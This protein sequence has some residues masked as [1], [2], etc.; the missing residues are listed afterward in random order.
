M[1][2]SVKMVIDDPSKFGLLATEVKKAM[3]QAAIA[4]VNIQA[5]LGRKAAVK[6]IEKSFTTRNTFTTRQ[7]QFTPMPESKYVKIS[8]IQST[9]GATDKAPYMARQEE[10]G[11]HTPSRGATLAIPTDYA[12]GGSSRSLVKRQM[13]VGNITGKM[14]VH[15]EA[16]LRKKAFKGKGKKVPKHKKITAHGSRK[17]WTVARAYIAFKHGLFLPYEGNS[18][19]RNLFRVTSFSKNGKKVKFKMV[20]VYSFEYRSTRTEE[21]PWLF[22]ASEMMGRQAQAIFNS[23][24]KKLEH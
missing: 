16:A 21:E 24:M 22:P 20:Q 4:T 7:V 10:G 6:N 18:D 5:A 17:S 2:S 19:K 14:K 11:F 13:R 12:R 23:Q 9:L 8:A 3:I 1:N 15:G